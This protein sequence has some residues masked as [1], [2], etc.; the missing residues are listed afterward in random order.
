MG[1]DP[2]R[3]TINGVGLVDILDTEYARRKKEQKRVQRLEF[4][5]ADTKR[6]LREIELLTAPSKKGEF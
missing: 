2:L 4:E 6:K 5:L 3:Q 1:Y